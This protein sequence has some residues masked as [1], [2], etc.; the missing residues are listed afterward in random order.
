MTSRT[1]TLLLWCLALLVMGLFARLGFWQLARSE[2]KRTMLE[3]SAAALRSRTPQPW[4]VIADPRRARDYDWVEV[5]GRFADAPPVLLDNQQRQGKVG[6]RAYRLFVLDDGQRLLVDLGWIAI[7]SDRTMPTLPP[8][9]TRTTVTG[10]LL[11]PPGA[12]LKIA[13]PQRLADGSLLATTLDPRELASRLRAPALAPRVLRPRPEPGFGFERD[14]DILPNTMPPERHVGYA[15][16][17]FA[18]SATV[19]ITALL[20]TWRASRAAKRLRSAAP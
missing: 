13:P 3:A 9:P 7:P 16:Q 20:L 18:L 15:V 10:L 6:V 8:A 19:L 4:S 11:P 14:F 5:R 17:W 1:R 2:Q 12:G